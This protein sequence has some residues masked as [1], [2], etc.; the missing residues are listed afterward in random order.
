MREEIDEG[1][2]ER[3]RIGRH[4]PSGLPRSHARLSKSP[5]MWQL[6]HDESPW[7]ELMARV[8]EEAPSID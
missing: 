1:A 5:K 8:V 6:A 3:S 2:E 4:R 7:L